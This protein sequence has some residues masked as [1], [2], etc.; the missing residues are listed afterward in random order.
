MI[1]L[2]ALNADGG[3]R[4]K[5]NKNSKSVSSFFYKRQNIAE[6]YVHTK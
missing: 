4:Q 3:D 6:T 5:N 2:A 1:I